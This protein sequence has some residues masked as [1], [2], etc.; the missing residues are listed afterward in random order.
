MPA[1]MLAQTK[2]EAKGAL[3]LHST[4]PVEEFGAWP[5]DLPAQIHGMDGDP[6]FAGDGDIDVA[7]KLA[8]S[9]G[10][11]ELFVYPGDAHLFADSSLPAYDEDA[12]A[13]MMERI[14]R[15]LRS[16]DLGRSADAQRD[17]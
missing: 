16:I 9:F 10:G 4:I 14:K 1:Q 3:L 2:P 8:A 5:A 11:V 7:R 6:F 15:F 12:A 13:L 17:R